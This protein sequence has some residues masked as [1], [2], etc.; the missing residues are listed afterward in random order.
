M[1]KE[2]RE[3]KC[4]Q[5]LGYSRVNS[6]LE[7]NIGRSHTDSRIKLWTHRESQNFQHSLCLV[8]QGITARL[9]QAGR[10]L[11]TRKA[12]A[13]EC[14]PRLAKRFS[15]NDFHKDKIVKVLRELFANTNRISLVFLISFLFHLP[16]ER[17]TFRV[18]RWEEK[19]PRKER[20]QEKEKQKLFWS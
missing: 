1:L 5:S 16:R 7:R 14:W 13:K 6:V 19:E 20:F 12:K 8:S 11:W 4:V 18:G 15:K 17:E 2:P 10:R 9:K 3:R